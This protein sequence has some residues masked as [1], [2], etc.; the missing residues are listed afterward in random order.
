VLRAVLCALGVPAERDD[1]V[2]HALRA[3]LR[4]RWSRPLEPV[5]VAWEG[6]GTTS[7]HL[8]AHLTRGRYSLV[9]TPEDGGPPRSAQGRLED[10]G[11]E[12]S[13]EV[14]G[15]RYAAR[16]LSLPGPLPHG[17]HHLRLEVEGVGVQGE[18]LVLSAP[19]RAYAPEGWDGARHWGV[20]LPLYAMHGEGS[21]GAG[22]LGDLRTLMRWVAERGGKH[23][24]H[25]G[26]IG[27]VAQPPA[28]AQGGE[29]ERPRGERQHPHVAADPLEP[30]GALQVGRGPH[31]SR[32]R[33][34]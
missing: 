25:L 11:V 4:A 1:D 20:F 9:L 7:L 23:E 30:R 22:N 17:Y 6:V 19:L 8:P 32:R 34:L 21:A 27:H 33:V 2:E 13:D 29:R 28:A 12:A 31:R 5:I 10:H 24:H 3:A 15:R 16:Q 14:D 18:A 26:R